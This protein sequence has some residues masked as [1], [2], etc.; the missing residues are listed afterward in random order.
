[1]SGRAPVLRVSRGRS[2]VDPILQVF[3]GQPDLRYFHNAAIAN[4]SARIASTHT[5]TPLAIIQTMLAP[6]MLQF[7]GMAPVLSEDFGLSAGAAVYTQMTDRHTP[8]P[9]EQAGPEQC[10]CPGRER[11]QPAEVEC[12][13]G[14]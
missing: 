3:G 14:Q 8:S 1:M 5:T 10:A 12:D 11:D 13:E 6:L 2:A 7:V 9:S 4:S